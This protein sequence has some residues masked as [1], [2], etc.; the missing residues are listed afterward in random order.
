MAVKELDLQYHE[1]KILTKADN[2]RISACTRIS[3]VQMNNKKLSK[4]RQSYQICICYEEHFRF[5]IYEFELVWLKE[6]GKD[7]IHVGLDLVARKELVRQ[8]ND[9]S[10]TI[11][12]YE[13][14]PL[15][16]VKEKG[17]AVED[18]LEI[19]GT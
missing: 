18:T 14:I 4:F 7:T 19:I 16:G 11:Q 12:S 15:L 6:H 1:K 2:L 5:Q 8:I 17:N 13:F 10:A 3:T 9:E